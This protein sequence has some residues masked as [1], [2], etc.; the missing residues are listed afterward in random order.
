MV[1]V[2][3][4]EMHTCH[5]VIPHYLMLRLHVVVTATL[6]RLVKL[7][8]T[9]IDCYEQRHAGAGV[10]KLLR[11][12][13]GTLVLVSSFLAISRVYFPLF[14][15]TVSV[16]IAR[17]SRILWI[18]GSTYCVVHVEISEHGMKRSTS[19]VYSGAC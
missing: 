4:F 14:Q 11:S 13:D 6:A 10:G 5:F 9:K 12:G 2:V 8:N 3:F 15:S 18:S 17:L 7:G 19:S 1:C 16:L